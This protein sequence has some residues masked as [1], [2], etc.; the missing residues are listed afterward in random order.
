MRM[1]KNW[2]SPYIPQLSISCVRSL[3]MRETHKKIANLDIHET[4]KDIVNLTIY[5]TLSNIVNL[6]EIEVQR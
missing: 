2:N 1:E 6:K 3:L 4:Q 5:E